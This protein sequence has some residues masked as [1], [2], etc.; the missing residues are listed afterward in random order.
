MQALMQ[1]EL[2]AWAEGAVGV[3]EESCE[4]MLPSFCSSAQRQALL[5]F[6]IC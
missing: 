3:V 2:H 6:I 1:E 4:G 5:A